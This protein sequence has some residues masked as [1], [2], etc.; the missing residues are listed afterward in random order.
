MLPGKKSLVGNGQPIFPPGGRTSVARDVSPWKTMN[1]YFPARRASE[2][3][4]GRSPWWAMNNFSF[5]PVGGR[6]QRKNTKS[7]RRRS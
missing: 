7:G 6:R 2:R 5:R 1:N 4:Q 3:C